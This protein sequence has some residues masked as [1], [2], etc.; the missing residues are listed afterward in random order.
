MQYFHWYYLQYFHWYYSLYSQLA[1]YS[2]V[3]FDHAYWFF[4]SIIIEN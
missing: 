3:T 2:Y 1:R 4:Y